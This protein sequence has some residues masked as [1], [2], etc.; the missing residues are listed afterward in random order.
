MMRNGTLAA[1][2]ARVL[3]ETMSRELDAVRLLRAAVDEQRAAVQRAD[4]DALRRAAEVV[5]DRSVVLADLA[6]ARDQ[7]LMALGAP[8]GAS[9]EEVVARLR[10]AGTD[11]DAV[12]RIGGVLRKEAIE[13]AR[14][15]AVVRRA[16]ERLAAHLAGVRS[17]ITSPGA[18]VYG[19]R[20]H[21]AG[22][23]RSHAVDL[24]H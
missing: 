4:A 19:R 8:S 23:D 17:H 2:H 9:L 18:G 24:R 10:A 6:R 5:R 14:S 3:A 11:A 20:G 12:E 7:S 1:T 16:G 13:V 21:L 15:I 22:V